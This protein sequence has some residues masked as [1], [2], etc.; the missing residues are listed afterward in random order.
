MP[1]II[2]VYIFIS[3][4]KD[5]TKRSVLF[6]AVTA[7]EEGLLGAKYYSMNPLYPLDKIPE[8]N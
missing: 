8:S 3:A 1:L 4:L 2:A 5:T 6:L 7:E